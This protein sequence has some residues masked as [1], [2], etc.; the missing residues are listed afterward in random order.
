MT[1][2]QDKPECDTWILVSLRTLKWSYFQSG[3]TGMQ[4]FSVTSLVQICCLMYTW[5]HGGLSSIWDLY[6]KVSV[7]G[8]LENSIQGED[9][10]CF[11]SR[12]VKVFALFHVRP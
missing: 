4:G 9:F 12:Q 6:F 3:Q 2:V 1:D 11:I 10:Q 5:V 7:N 8:P